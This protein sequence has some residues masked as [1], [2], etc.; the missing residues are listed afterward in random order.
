MKTV[1][2]IFTSAWL[3]LLC[4][5]AVGSVE[6][7]WSTPLQSPDK[8]EIDGL[9]LLITEQMDKHKVAGV[10]VALVH[11]GNLIYA[12]GFG[13]ADIENNAPVIAHDT[14]FRWGSVSKTF[15]WIALLQLVEQGKVDLDADINNYLVDVSIPDTFEQPITVRDLM[16][17]MPGFEDLILGH[18]FEKDPEQVLT[19]T[20]Y[21]QTFKPERVRPPGE[22]FSY[23]NYG[24][25]LAG[26]I[27]ANVSKMSFEDYIE[28]HIF[29]PLGMASSTFREPLPTKF[30]ESMRPRLASRVS[31]SFSPSGNTYEQVNHF[32]FISG[33]GPAGAMSAPV[34]DMAQFALALLNQC[35]GLLAVE[36][37]S[38]MREPLTSMTAANQITINYGFFEHREIAGHL[39]FGHNGGTDYFHSEM[40]IYPELDFAVLLSTNTTTGKGFNK[41]IEKAIVER[42]FGV[43]NKPVVPV[44][45]NDTSEPAKLARYSGY[46]IDTR[47]PVS[48][49]EILVTFTQPSTRV[50]VEPDEQLSIAVGS[51]LF[52]ANWVSGHLFF[53]KDKGRYFEFVENEKGEIINLKSLGSLDRVSTF[54]TPE[55]K[56]TLILISVAVIFLSF[57]LVLV[58]SLKRFSVRERPSQQ[59]FRRALILSGCAWVI[60]LALLLYGIIHDIGAYAYPYDFPSIWIKVAS[61]FCLFSSFVTLIPIQAMLSL[62]SDTNVG[63]VYKMVSLILIVNLLLLISQ[64]YSLNLL[65][66]YFS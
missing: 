58:L 48:N 53:D 31:K 16:S 45:A 42:F 14:L 1:S 17:H 32:T 47:R 5:F 56:L 23:S 66:L 63:K 37:C 24:S 60:S 27:V 59:R 6:S 26:Q 21:L 3:I 64:L 50:S 4:A 29:M 2:H 18:I 30:K 61:A 12:R 22:L 57:L 13:Y 19:L 11:K 40:G 55:T 62:W 25:A 8:E 65:R 54:Q 51:E 9:E 38:M 44:N 28:R 33:I 7:S 35:K 41:E 52:K 49:A 34:T 15:T 46:Y 43:V 36:M 20:A 39:R 10:T